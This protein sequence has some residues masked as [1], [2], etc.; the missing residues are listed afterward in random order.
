MHPNAIGNA[1]IRPRVARLGGTGWHASRNDGRALRTDRGVLEHRPGSTTHVE[2][3]GRRMLGSPGN[4]IACPVGLPVDRNG[5]HHD[6]RHRG[7]GSVAAAARR[8]AGPHPVTVAARRRRRHRLAGAAAGIH[9]RPGAA[10][11]AL[12]QA[13]AGRGGAGGPADG[14]GAAAARRHMDAARRGRREQHRGDISVAPWT[15]ATHVACLH[16]VAIA[17]TALA[18]GVITGGTARLDTRPTATI[19][20]LLQ[21]VAGGARNNAPTH[22]ECP[23]GAAG[24]VGERGRRGRRPR[25]HQG[26]VARHLGAASIG[27]AG[28]HA[29]DIAAL[30][31]PVIALV[32]APPS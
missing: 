31:N 7:T 23:G 27:V 11:D 4:A 29:I 3:D 18:A 6:D 14:D 1:R 16:A 17:A 12:L 30:P 24:R 9:L 2:T 13:I 22:G 15:A 8:V 10:V 19:D 26:G 20:L 21:S 28:L 25:H 32:V 5:H